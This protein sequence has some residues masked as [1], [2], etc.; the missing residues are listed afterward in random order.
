MG[1]TR[2]SRGP[3]APLI[4]VEGPLGAARVGLRGGPRASACGLTPRGRQPS[5]CSRALAPMGSRRA[6]LPRQCEPRLCASAALRETCPPWVAVRAE[7]PDEAPPQTAEESGVSP[8]SLE[9]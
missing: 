5:A 2:E 8:A 7:A 6:L 1:G 4:D 9:T 3:G